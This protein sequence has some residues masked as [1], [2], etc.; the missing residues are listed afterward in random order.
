MERGLLSDTS[1]ASFVKWLRAQPK[2]TPVAGAFHLTVATL[3]IINCMDRGFAKVEFIYPDLDLLNQA[4]VYTAT[5]GFAQEIDSETLHLTVCW[6]NVT[7]D[8][9][10]GP[11]LAYW[12]FLHHV[13]HE[14]G[15]KMFGDVNAQIDT[16]YYMVKMFVLYALFFVEAKDD[17]T[18]HNH[19]VSG[20]TP[21]SATTFERVRRKLMDEEHA[22][23]CSAD[24]AN[25]NG[26]TIRF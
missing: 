23:E 13:R 22:L 6:T 14:L 15:I 26:M 25:T 12:R 21:L 5:E 8:I 10:G 3:G 20:F 9:V 2:R 7:D 19:V 4:A 17:S 18:Q 24:G 11:L 1:L 16:D